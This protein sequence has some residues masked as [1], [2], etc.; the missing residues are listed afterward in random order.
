[1]KLQLPA[2]LVLIGLLN[3]F[4]VHAQT[5]ITIGSGTAAN[6]ATSYPCPLQDNN[7]GQRAQYLYTAA[8]LTAAGMQAGTITAIRFN[9]TGMGTFSGKAEALAVKMGTTLTTSLDISTWEPVPATNLFGPLDYVPVAGVNT[10]TFSTPFVWDGKR[11][12]VVEICNGAAN[13]ATAV[14]NTGN[15]LITWTTGLAFNASH[16]FVANNMGSLCGT[17]GTANN[18]AVN[19]R[20]NIVFS[21]TPAAACSGTPEGGVTASSV[22]TICPDTDFLL[23]LTGSSVA[24]GLSYQWQ[25]S[26]NN[27]T[28]ATIPGATDPF[29]TTRQSAGTWYRCVVTCT[30]GG[31]S[32]A[33]DPVFVSSPALISGTF[34]I[35]SNQPAGG[36]NFQSFNDAY[37]HIKCGIDGPVVFNVVAGSGPYNE[38]LIINPVPGASA[39]N[40]VVFN[41]NGATIK[42]PS[43]NTNE[44][45]VIKL[46]GADH[47]RLNNLVIDA[48]TPATGTYYGYGVQLINDADSNTISNCTI[49][50]NLLSAYNN[51]YAGV[52]M[53]SSATGATANGATLCDS[54]S[55]INN[56]ITGGYVSVTVVGSNT[57]AIARNLVQG[58]RLRDF[59]N[60]GVYV[61][62]SV[63]TVVKNNDIS[64]PALSTPGDFYG[65][66]VSTL[67]TLSV[68][69]GNRIHD[70][71]SAA[72]GSTSTF[73]AIQHSGTDAFEGLENRVTNN[74]VYRVNGMGAQYGIY[75]NSSDYVLYHHNTISLDDVASTATNVARAYYQNQQAV[76]IQ[77]FNNIITITRGGAGVKHALYRSTPATSDS[78]NNNNYYVNAPGGALGFYN[79]VTYYV[80]NDWKKGVNQDGASFS[81]N[82]FY[83]D[84]ANGDYT[85]VSLVLDNRGS[86]QG[87]TVDIKGAL[88]SNSA[89]DLGAFEFSLPPCN[90]SPAGGNA[91]AFPNSDVCMALPVQLGLEGNTTGTGQTVQW[92][93]ASTASGTWTNL[94][95]VLPYPDTAVAAASNIYYRAVLTCGGNT[96][97]SNPVQVTVN[98][99]LPA[100]TYTINP[101]AAAG[102]GNFQSFGTAIT[103]MRCGIGG[104]VTFNVYPGTYNERIRINAITGAGANSRVTFQSL[105]GD[106]A[107]VILTSG[108]AT[109]SANYVLQLDS[110]AYVSFRNLSVTTTATTYARAIDIANISSYDSIVNCNVTAPATTATANTS[111]AIFSNTMTGSGNVIRGN[112]VKGGAYGV[113]LSGVSLTAMGNENII[114]GNDVSGAF[115]SGIYATY[116]RRM[117]IKQNT[118]TTAPPASATAYAIYTMY[119]DTAYQFT[120]NNITIR[121]TTGN[122]YG[123][124]ANLCRSTAEVSGVISNNR[125]KAV[126]NVTGNVYGLY[127]Y[128]TSGNTTV[129]NVIAVKTTANTAYGIYSA[130]GVNVKYWNNSVNNSSAAATATNMAAYFD[131]ITYSYGNINIRNNIFY[132]SGG[133]RAMG[134]SLFSFINSDYNLLYST[135]GVL[136]SST[137]PVATYATLAEWQNASGWDVNSMNYAPAFDNAETLTPDLSSSH[138]WAMHGRGVQLAG[139]A[140]DINNNVRPVS[141]QDG[142]PD[143]GAYE[144]VPTSQPEVLTAS[145][146]APV[147]GATQTFTL[148]SDVV[149]SITWGANVPASF[150]LRRYSG[151]KPQGVAA[152]AQ[153][154]YYYLSADMPAGNYN[155]DIR[156]YYVPS[157]LGDVPA[158]GYIKSGKA[159]LGGSWSVNTTSVTDTL[160]NT[161]AESGVP[162]PAQMTGLTDGNK[163]VSR[164]PIIYQTFD[165]SNRGTEFWLSYGHVLSFKSINNQELLLYLNA[166]KEAHVTVRVNGTT[167][168]KTYTIA[169]NTTV[170]TQPIPKTGINDARLQAEGMYDRGISITSDV[171]VA[172]YAALY[173]PLGETSNA[174]TMLLPSGTYG[175][176]Y[177]SINM[178]QRVFSSYNVNPG[179]SWINIVATHDSTVVQITPSQPSMGGRDAGVPFTVTLMRGQVYQLMGA[180]IKDE[181]GQNSY[182]YSYDLT[183]TRVLSIANEHGNCYPVAVFSGSS[184]TYMGCGTPD[185]LIGDGYLQQNFPASAW[186]TKFLT[187]PVA[188]PGTPATSFNLLYRVVVKDPATQVKRNGTVLSGLVV[189]GNYYEFPSNTADY[190]EAD[191]PVSVAQM[192]PSPNYCGNTGG[193][194]EITY[195]SALNQGVTSSIVPRMMHSATTEQSTVV[196]VP[197]A[198]LA[199]LRIDNSNTFSYTY[200]HP[201]LAGYTVVVKQWSTPISGQA[202]VTC[203]Q[204]FTGVSYGSGFLNNYACNI[205]IR[206]S[207]PGISTSIKNTL[208]STGSATNE[209]TCAKAPFRPSIR[210]PLQA[211]SITWTF[212]AI[213]GARPAGDITQANPVAAG[214]TVVDGVT[215]YNYVLPQDVSIDHAGSYVLPVVVKHASFGG[216]SKTLAFAL[217]ILVKDAPVSDFTAAPAAVCAGKPIDLTGTDNTPGFVVNRWNWTFSDAATAQGQQTSKTFAVAGTQAVS[218]RIVTEEGCIGDTAKDVTIY[219]L[220]SVTLASNTLTICPNETGALAIAS[221]VTGITYNWYTQETGGTSVHSGTSY[222]VTATGTYY[223]EAVSAEGCISNPRGKAVVAIYAALPSPVVTVDSAGVNF[224]RFR[225]NNVPGATG[226]DVSLD[227][228]A[229]FIT[230]AGGGTSLTYTVTPLAPVTQATLVVR[231]N[232]AVLCQTGLSTAVTGQTLPDQIFI[233][234]SFTPN[235]DQRNDT[236][237]V[238]GYVFKN[239]KVMVFN[240]WG[241]KVFDATGAQVSWDGRF[242][243]KEMPSG[244]YMYVVQATLQDGTVEYRKGSINLIR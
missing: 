203:D 198:A 231:A 98:P 148:G 120:G 60:Y 200:A 116:N 228:G 142:V 211:E 43:V 96:A 159:A 103:A 22:T 169:A 149:A 175:Y 38:Q 62:G 91:V 101:A 187:A 111:A 102:S 176:D 86:A 223:A 174:A 132:H 185:P 214:T 225:W 193:D 145:P 74:L 14:T 196:I 13:N 243:G 41:G 110:A 208:N 47:I 195:V 18:G 235:N 11:N 128:A 79:N 123:I 218:L 54:N 72:P 140:T 158:Y 239:L 233:P 76:G 34:T 224:V 186:G 7:E 92:Q 204:P 129:N 39:A 21:Y 215:Y 178:R 181:P 166:E 133:N 99:G 131:H 188:V 221:P 112:V 210:I 152:G 88:R 222:S 17:A 127:E 241:Q 184:H 57:Q 37:N 90:T 168:E 234:N 63:G 161:I 135:G 56:T 117:Q 55:I 192:A 104:A 9:V 205:A 80:L 106:P 244:V 59:F 84:T 121:N 232:G 53:N 58:N 67:N 23:S 6:A 119:C 40:A 122:A 97:I 155:A 146:A 31:A 36:G 49:T 87:V 70:P 27:V 220:P 45:A 177:T 162:V 236:W 16:S 144:F 78:L 199:S 48:T 160:R 164:S 206:I 85:P 170:V 65:V 118:I 50:S 163:T 136:L 217:N 171:P 4:T 33:S 229:N 167:Y 183:G 150:A 8:E 109:A 100:G 213:T 189:P 151:V 216:C 10:L 82:P 141:L 143:L 46:N 113:M 5:N 3:F 139:N 35:N 147:A 83:K 126:D 172:A 107:S 29:L 227:G 180:V 194:V 115:Y 71:F 68:I 219:S 26:V 201:N 197:T 30:N 137:T 190:I 125:I 212:S 226:Y 182:D 42:F 69:T 51:A 73:Y 32:D 66:M 89:P 15:P 124:Y 25:N 202:V 12:I 77:F 138:V 130:N 24:Q 156:Q 230:P 81:Y 108:T 237:Q 153:S 242:N 165:S 61:A 44:R 20:P 207:N 191:Q 2:L 93:Y 75:N 179:S 238:Y 209:Y 114:E 157:W 154:M 94:G 28:W 1:M 134:V 173:V 95:G 64:R 19:T 52:V 105:T 240:Q